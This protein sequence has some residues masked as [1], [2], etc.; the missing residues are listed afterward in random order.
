[1]GRG[2]DVNNYNKKLLSLLHQGILWMERPVSIDVDLIIEIIGL[3]IDGEK[4]KK[5][6]DDKTKDKA[7]AEEMKNKYNIDRGSRGLIINKINKPVTRLETKLMACKLLRKCHK[8]EALE[9]VIATVLQ[10]TKRGLLSWSPYLLKLFL[11]DCKDAQYLGTD[12]HYSWLIILIALVG[13]GNPNTMD[14]SKG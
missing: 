4:M 12:F 2:K 13:W 10:C 14:F 3:L 11:D 5:Y 9:R 8:E 1:L 6:L 7:L